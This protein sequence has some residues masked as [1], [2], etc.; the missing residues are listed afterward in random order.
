MAE[1]K[2]RTLKVPGATLYCEI[3]GTGPTLLIIAG[4]PQDA[5]VFAGLVRE[6]G[7]RYRVV[8]YD[9]RGNS[10][11]RFDDGAER[12]DVDVQADDAAALLATLGNGPAHVFGTSGGAQI[13]LN[14]AARHPERVATLIAHEAP[15]AMLLDDPEGQLEE[16]QALTAIY[17]KDGV[18][19]A[20]GAFFG[21]N[22]LDGPPPEGEAMPEF[23]MGPEEAETFAR[24]SGN[25]EYWL[26]HGM[27]PLT[28]HRPDVTA[29]KGLPF[30]H[31]TAE[32]IPY[33][34]MLWINQYPRE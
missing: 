1:T 26:K 33:T 7:E 9:P 16:L 5:G 4:G 21:M 13:G 14:L 23:E 24:V 28:L 10:R 17:E 18:D 6:L 29:L 15:T 30:M 32:N 19:A 3:T 2:V 27:T 8:A 20:M 11:S 25:F 12:L 31:L 22:G 34:R